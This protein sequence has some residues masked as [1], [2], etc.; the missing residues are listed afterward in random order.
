[1]GFF[2]DITGKLIN[3]TH[4]FRPKRTFNRLLLDHHSIEMKQHEIQCL[5]KRQK[6]TIVNM[7][8]NIFETFTVEE[9]KNYKKVVWECIEFPTYKIGINSFLKE[10][11]KRKDINSSIN[12]YSIDGIKNF[13]ITLIIYMLFHSMMEN[14]LPL[15]QTRH[16][17]F[18]EQFYNWPYTGYKPH[19]ID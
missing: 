19:N 3:R 15:N 7:M 5:T 4:I 12:F 9:K 1:M 14:Q 6:Q 13:Q 2:W 10:Y 16:H 11:S 17:D 18:Y 8:V